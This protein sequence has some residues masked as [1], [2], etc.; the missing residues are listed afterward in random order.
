MD[1]DR[2]VIA[3]NLTETT[4]I[5]PRGA[6]CY[7]VLPNPGGGHDRIVVLI[8]SHGG[9]WVEKWENMK[10][11]GNFRVK[12]LPPEHSLYGEMRLWD[13][14]VDRYLGMLVLAHERVLA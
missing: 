5:G 6:R 11:L 8:R 4:N 12:T 3:C 9:R 7:V 13:Y 2:R 1:D 10:R 14:D